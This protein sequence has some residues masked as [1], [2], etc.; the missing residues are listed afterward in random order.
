MVWVMATSAALLC[1]A[2]VALSSLDGSHSGTVLTYS[3]R[4]VNVRDIAAQTKE[5][6]L[7][8][9]AGDHYSWNDQQKVIDARKNLKWKAWHNFHL[10]G[11][12]NGGRSCHFGALESFAY[13]QFYGDSGDICNGVDS[14]G[15][16]GASTWNK[17]HEWPG[18]P[19]DWHTAMVNKHKGRDITSG[20]KGAPPLDASAEAKMSKTQF[21][22]RVPSQAPPY[23]DSVRHTPGRFPEH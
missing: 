5:Q 9:E 18:T 10:C 17:E 3:G 13:S 16:N 6:L 21:L 19:A 1:C 23:S 2:L 4:V 12:R 15:C 7:L 22:A 8:N 11:F 20:I 14:T